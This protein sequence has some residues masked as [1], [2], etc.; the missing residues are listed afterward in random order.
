[1]NSQQERG[2]DDFKMPQKQEEDKKFNGKKQQADEDEI[3][4]L[5]DIGKTDPKKV[6]IIKASSIG[7]NEMSREAR[8]NQLMSPPE[9]GKLMQCTIIRD[10]KG[11]NRISPK[12]TL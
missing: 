12:Y 5:S 4:P 3:K 11:F 9:K 2:N 7:L 8:Y 10:K 1:M 6:D